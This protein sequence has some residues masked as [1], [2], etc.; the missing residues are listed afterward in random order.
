MTR[1]GSR[2]GEGRKSA[3]TGVVVATVA[4]SRRPWRAHHP[5]GRVY[6]CSLQ[7]RNRLKCILIDK[8]TITNHF[9]SAEYF[10]HHHAGD[11]LIHRVLLDQLL[12]I[13]TRPS[14]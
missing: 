14:F 7:R 9:S 13:Q 1:L 5:T 6:S 2:G 11:R 4:P 12:R 8:P 3:D 10:A